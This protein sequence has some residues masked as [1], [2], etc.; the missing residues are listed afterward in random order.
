MKG[1]LFIAFFLHLL[2]LL[3]GVGEVMLFLETDTKTDK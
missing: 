1:K 2:K 3:G